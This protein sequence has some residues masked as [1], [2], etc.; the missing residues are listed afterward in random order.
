M[1]NA[2]I[3]FRFLYIAFVALIISLLEAEENRFPKWKRV[4]FN[5][6][7]NYSEFNIY[8]D[9]DCNKEM[10]SPGNL[11]TLEDWDEDFLFHYFYNGEKSFFPRKNIHY[12]EGDGI[13]F[14]SY[15]L[16]A[17][18]KI[19]HFSRKNNYYL[20][21]SIP[22]GVQI[23]SCKNIKKSASFNKISYVDL[24]MRLN[25]MI[26]E[27]LFVFFPSLKILK[28]RLGTDRDLKHISLL[29]SLTMLDLE[30]VKIG[31]E[32]V[33][34]LAKL[35]NLRILN[36]SGTKISDACMDH[37]IKLRNLSVLNLSYTEIKDLGIKLLE[38]LPNLRILNLTSTKITDTGMK[39]LKNLR[40]LR[41]LKLKKAG[42]THFGIKHLES[43]QHLR[44]LDLSHTRVDN[45][46]MKY[47]CGLQNLQDLSLCNTSVGNSGMKHLA[48]LQ[49]LCTLRLNET[50]VNHKGLMYLKNF[51][52]LRSLHLDRIKTPATMNDSGPTCIEVPPFKEFDKSRGQFKKEQK[53]IQTQLS[54]N[55]PNIQVLSLNSHYVFAELLSPFIMK[56]QNLCELYYVSSKN[57][58]AISLRNLQNLQVVTLSKISEPFAYLNKLQTLMLIEIQD[59]KMIHL[60]KLKNLRQLF[61]WKADI[62]DGSLIHLRRLKNLWSLSLSNSKISGKGLIHLRNLS[63]L[64]AIDLSGTNLSD[65]GFEQLGKILS[66]YVVDL[67]SVKINEKK[68]KFLTNLKNLRNIKF[69]PISWR[70]F[71][72]KEKLDIRDEGMIHLGKLSKLRSLDLSYSKITDRGLLHLIKLR[73]LRKIYLRQTQVSNKGLKSLK[74]FRHLRILDLSGTNISDRG[75]A[76]LKKL[77]HLR[78]LDLSNTNIS[79]KGLACLAELQNLYDLKLYSTKISNGELKRLKEILP[80]TTIHY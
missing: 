50:Y 43:L 65:K 13:S 53:K 80:A 73:N 51:S 7:H 33:K 18:D 8:I 44:R 28:I 79:N 25:D 14:L 1:F 42:I 37:L 16:P 60:A 69:I 71:G 4:A 11:I 31:D 56:L 74:N 47:L 48:K 35:P 34:H 54:K 9:F 2:Q 12:P 66:L 46:G 30:N 29:K 68:L 52:N 27:R 38:N 76:Y 75:L 41:E 15:P 19:I 77:P 62:N 24:D 39:H 78:V 64:R 36:L 58:G 21:N 49:N 23:F 59:D 10:I 40:H 22:Y 61:L 6:S 26:I 17:G 63:N 67:K 20:V 45:S 32:G 5:Y 72:S 57:Y 55:F 3:N 70:I